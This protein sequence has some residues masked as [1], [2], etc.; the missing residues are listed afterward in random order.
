MS[1]SKIGPVNRMGVE[2][3]SSLMSPGEVERLQENM[4]TMAASYSMKAVQ[5]KLFADLWSEIPVSQRFTGGKKKLAKRIFV[6]ALAK[7]SRGE[8]L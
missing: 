6:M 3:E 2:E 1:R 7:M 4:R 5:E 8:G